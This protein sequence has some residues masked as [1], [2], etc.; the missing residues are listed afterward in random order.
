MKKN[1][2]YKG[3]FAL[4]AAASLA[5]CASDYLEREPITVT[6]ETKMFSTVDNAQRAVYGACRSMCMVYEVGQKVPFM[7][8][9]AWIN[10]MYGEV[11]GSDAYYQFW[12]TNF[13]PEFMKGNYLLQSNYWMP[14]MPW[15]YSY[16]LIN[17][18]NKVLDNIDAAAGTDRDRAYVKAQALTL[19]AHGYIKLI[20]LFAPRWEDANGGDVEVAPLRLTSTTADAPL[21]TMTAICDQIYKDLDDA[22]ALYTQAGYDRQFGWE[23]GIEI[24]QGLYARIAAV[25]HDWKKVKEM[26][27]AA[28]KD[29]P[30]MSGE[31]YIDGFNTANQEWMW[32]NQNLNEDS[33][34]GFF[35]WGAFNACNG[36]YVASWGEGAG[37]INY[38]LYRKMDK[39]DIRRQLYFTPDS[40]LPPIIRKSAFWNMTYIDDSN[41]NLNKVNNGTPTTLAV[42]LR[43]Y[44][45]SRVPSAGINYFL[46]LPYR[47]NADPESNLI[48]VVP[49][50]AQFKFWGSGPFSNT[51]VPFMRGA[52]MAFLEAEAAY[53][54]GDE[55]RAREIL[56]EVN[57]K[58]VEG[59]STT[60]TGDALLD[61]IRTSKRIELW[62][63]GFC[64]TDL[65]RW[66]MHMIRRPWVRGDVNS[67]NIPPL[68]QCDV[69]PTD[70][71]GWRIAIPQVETDYNSLIKAFKIQ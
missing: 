42:A 40:D 25:K 21:A 29:F 12:Q 45:A 50:G 3:A 10:T 32:Y 70:I 35:C 23:P 34:L 51:S 61:E 14:Q 28:R 65:K 71:N 63:E 41:M 47:D 27:A 46:N 33:M 68:Y 30:I 62:G 43:A 53:E 7:N 44:S 19:R 16:N 64:W 17:Q 52:E 49:F 66:N 20:Q 37:A 5:S 69:K 59:Y 67:N 57:G 60:A 13:G 15:T 11:F 26:A 55:N 48:G 9:E 38:D 4:V 39:K 1:I 31:Q 54:L 36:G 18:V 56:V 24:A 58:R 22:I 6:D 8:G 2:I